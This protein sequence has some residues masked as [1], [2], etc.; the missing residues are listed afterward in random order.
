MK[1]NSRSSGRAYFPS[2]APTEWSYTSAFNGHPNHGFV[3]VGGKAKGKLGG[4]SVAEH[5]GAWSNPKIISQLEAIRNAA[6]KEEQAFLAKYKINIGSGNWG[7]LIRAFTLI[8]SSEA[9][10]KRNLQLLK[11]VRD[12]ET[13]IYHHFTSFMSSYVQSAARRIIKERLGTLTTAPL[14]PILHSLIDEIMETALRDMFSMTDTKYKNGTIDTHAKKNKRGRGKEIQVYKDLLKIIGQLMNTPFKQLVID[15]LGLTKSFIQDT[16]NAQVQKQNGNKDVVLPKLKSSITNGNVKGNIQEYFEEF[17][18]SEVGKKLDG[19]V[20]TSNWMTL[21]TGTKGVKS[22]VTAYNILGA[23]QGTINLLQS[24][25]GKN[26][27]NRV[28][29]IINNEKFFDL[30]R[31]AEG[32]IIFISDKNYQIKS[33]GFEGYMAQGKVKLSNLGAF[34]SKVGYP[35]NVSTLLDYLANCGQQMLFGVGQ[36]SEIL[37][38]VATQIGHFLFDDLTVTNTGGINRVHLLNLSGF[39]VPLSVYMGAVIQAARSAEQQMSKYVNTKFIG[40]GKLPPSGGWPGGTSDFE[41]FR[42]RRLNESYLEVHFMRDVANFITS[43]V[44]I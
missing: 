22:D 40:K 38:G 8:F 33:S 32:E 1:D 37:S 11:Q 4:A 5:K 24:T 20:T 27:S 15:E 19:I 30:V 14:A 2:D 21:R 43:Q 6:V 26:D 31:N 42:Q 35:G 44:G 29:A 28:N 12:G 23:A 18:T 34:L 41:A 13:S 10:F 17:F 36:T 16:I 39:Y 9:A 3:K 7:D 25:A